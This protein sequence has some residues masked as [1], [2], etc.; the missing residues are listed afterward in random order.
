VR[1]ST[2]IEFIPTSDIKYLGPNFISQKSNSL[3]FLKDKPRI[4]GI[5]IVNKDC[6]IVPELLALTRVNSQ[7]LL[8]STIRTIQ[9][10]IMHRLLKFVP[11]KTKLTTYLSRLVKL[12]SVVYVFSGNSGVIRRFLSC[13]YGGNPK[14][15]FPILRQQVSKLDYTTGFSASLSL[16]GHRLLPYKV[17]DI[18]KLASP[19]LIGVDEV[20]ETTILNRLQMIDTRG[21]NQM[22]CR[23]IYL[24]NLS[25]LWCMHQ[26]DSRQL[27]LEKVSLGKPIG[28]SVFEGSQSRYE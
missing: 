4:S 7:D 5:P 23:N 17:R 26:R 28:L 11:N 14:G 2:M 9:S 19:N 20:L 1:S 25:S 16:R 12:V 24:S 13:V 22:Y 21:Y 6:T 15:V 3:R 27:L 10:R 8:N 18:Q